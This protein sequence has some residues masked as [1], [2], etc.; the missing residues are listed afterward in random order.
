V[1][2]VFTNSAKGSRRRKGERKTNTRN[3]DTEK[4]ERKR[5]KKRKRG[6]H[7]DEDERISISPSTKHSEELTHTQLRHQLRS[8][9]FFFTMFHMLMDSCSFLDETRC[10]IHEYLVFMFHKFTPHD[11]IST[12]LPENISIEVQE[13]GRVIQWT[14]SNWKA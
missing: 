13:R 10:C 6:K 3:M 14:V 8:F 1:K 9:E 5:G 2:R 12:P 4:K 7:G 11:A